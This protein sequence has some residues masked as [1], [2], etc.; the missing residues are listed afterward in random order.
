MTGG[1]AIRKF[2]YFI[3]SGVTGF[4]E[5]KGLLIICVTVQHGTVFFFHVVKDTFLLICMPGVGGFQHAWVAKDG[6]CGCVWRIAA[7]ALFD[8]VVW[9]DWI[10]GISM[11]GVRFG[12]LVLEK[13]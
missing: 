3:S 12:E 1:G 13:Q 2:K 11:S 6:V 10:W 9:I 5:D 7:P 4:S 8:E